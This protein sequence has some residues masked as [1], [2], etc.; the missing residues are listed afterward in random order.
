MLAVVNEEFNAIPS[1]LAPVPFVFFILVILF[2]NTLTFILAPCI[3]NPE[4]TPVVAVVKPLTVFPEI[5]QLLAPTATIP[6]DT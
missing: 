6:N 3:F 2:L 5:L 1:A 4:A